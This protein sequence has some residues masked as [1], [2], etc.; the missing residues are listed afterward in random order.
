MLWRVRNSRGRPKNAPAGFIHPCRP[1]VSQRPPR[2]EGWV[3]ELKHD[4]Y[5]LQIHVRDGRVRLYTMNA[6]DWTK[7]YPRIVEEAARIKG[8]AILD[9]EVVCL[10]AEGVAQFD[11]LRACADNLAVA[12]AFDLF[13]LNGDD[14]RG[15]PLIERKAA[16]HKLLPCH[17]TASNMWTVRGD[18]D[19]MF[20]AT[21]RL[22]L[23]GMVSKMSLALS[24]R[25]VEG[26][27]QPE[28]QGPAAMRGVYGT[29]WLPLL[30]APLIAGLECCVCVAESPSFA[31]SRHA[32]R[33][34]RALVL[35][36]FSTSARLPRSTRR[37]PTEQWSSTS[38]LASTHTTRWS[39]S[40]PRRAGRG[41]VRTSRTPF[42]P[43]RSKQR[44]LG[45]P[46]GICGT[47]THRRMPTTGY[48][49]SYFLLRD[50][51]HR[52]R[53]HSRTRRIPRCARRAHRRF[54]PSGIEQTF[55]ALRTWN[56]RV[57]SDLV[58]V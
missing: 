17:V 14:L 6:A 38:S 50:N 57:G 26:L 5:R 44:P 4:G 8:S 23:E 32:N 56:V 48:P 47:G 12:C 22:G 21:C 28:A 39:R 42:Q 36:D 3:H 27:A 25:P 52:L 45:R 51:R 15:K 33:R 40:T 9:A 35:D 11:I 10:D 20:E 58:G 7:R 24:I 29:F 41:K 54:R 16:L 18:G 55:V 1:T 2:G 49:A 43:S 19:K 31:P 53:R 34:Y 37:Q 46:R 30:L 13:M